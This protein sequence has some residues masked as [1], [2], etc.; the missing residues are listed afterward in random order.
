MV[1][2]KAGRMDEHV[3]VED[4]SLVIE[5]ANIGVNVRWLIDRLPEYVGKKAVWEVLLA[6]RK[7]DQVYIYEGAV[8]GCI[9]AP[10]GKDEFGFDP[11]F[12]PEGAEKT[13]AEDKPNHYNARALAVQSLMNNKIFKIVPVINEW[14][15]L[16]Q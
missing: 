2:H 6:F 3:L 9:V 14:E 11:V 8:P 15:G 13:L 4:T 7:G 16:W 5:G 1:A 10:R 12:M